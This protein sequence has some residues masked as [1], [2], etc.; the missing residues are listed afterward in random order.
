MIISE[1]DISVWYVYYY[2]S[3]S[4]SIKR[5]PIQWPIQLELTKNGSRISHAWNILQ[6]IWSFKGEMYS[7]TCVGCILLLIPQVFCNTRNAYNSNM[8]SF[9]R[10]VDKRAIYRWHN[11]IRTCA[12]EC[13]WLFRRI[14]TSLWIIVCLNL[15]A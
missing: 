9:F 5:F 15:A 10:V 14:C 4:D 12:G 3:F 1:T 7:F 2:S 13:D 8:T 6:M 11:R